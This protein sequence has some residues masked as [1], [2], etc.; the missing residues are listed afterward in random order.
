M[1]ITPKLFSDLTEQQSE[2]KQKLMQVLQRYLPANAVAYCAELIMLHKLH[3]HIEVE[4][5]SRY[6]D[7]SPHEGK[8]N[9]IS[10][11]HN[12]SPFEFLI[13][14]VHELAHHTAYKKYGPHHEAHGAEWKQEFQLCMRPFFMLDVFPEDLK[15]IL[16][17]HMHNPKYSQ[18][19]DVK[20][21]QVLKK[22]DARR[23]G[24][25]TLSQLAD[26]IL[27]RMKGNKTIMRRLE[28]LRTYVMCETLDGKKYRVH[29]M[30][31][32]ERVEA[33]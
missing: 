6:G 25:I 2:H 32:V 30:A 22:Y 17:K 7:Y 19:A 5:K 3:L 18:A 13:T 9:R 24:E 20:L 16:A 23:A 31:A 1:P 15:Q 33:V 26:G 4:R 11:N 8:G 12:L 14:F 10:I 29:A 21:L 27:F 28:K